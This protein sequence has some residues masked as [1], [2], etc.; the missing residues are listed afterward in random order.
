M[1]TNRQKTKKKVV[2]FFDEMDEMEIH[3]TF[4][5][6]SI[7]VDLFTFLSDQISFCQ[8]EVQVLGLII[9]YSIHLWAWA[10]E[11]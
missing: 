2:N 7:N 6:F 9:G 4:A 10:H 8:V 11:G 1:C 3:E 5:V